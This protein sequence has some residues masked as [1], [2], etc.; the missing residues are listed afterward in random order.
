MICHFAHLTQGGFFVF[1]SVR[2]SR[3]ALEFGDEDGYATTGPVEAWTTP[4]DDRVVHPGIVLSRTFSS[5]R[6]VGRAHDT[7]VASVCTNIYENIIYSIW[8][9]EGCCG[10]ERLRVAFNE[11]WRAVQKGA[12]DRGIIHRVIYARHVWDEF[13]SCECVSDGLLDVHYVK[14]I[15]RFAL[16]PTRI[17]FMAQHH[18]GTRV[19]GCIY[20]DPKCNVASFG[21]YFVMQGRHATS[22]GIPLRHVVVRRVGVGAGFVVDHPHFDKYAKCVFVHHDA[23]DNVFETQTALRPTDS[24]EEIHEAVLRISDRRREIAREEYRAAIKQQTFQL[25][26]DETRYETNP[27]DYQD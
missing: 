8:L 27:G 17:H 7:L 1:E 20:I 4:D 3:T 22:F 14:Y 23:V 26:D 25:Q 10:A 18:E 9:D 13:V 21:E 12:E 16:N 6:I 5:P 11:Y 15:V 2:V 24:F 19:Y